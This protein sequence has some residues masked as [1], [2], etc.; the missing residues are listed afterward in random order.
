MKDREVVTSRESYLRRGVRRS[1]FDDTSE[2]EV[3]NALKNK[4]WEI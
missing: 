1:E 2:K 3:L 4:K